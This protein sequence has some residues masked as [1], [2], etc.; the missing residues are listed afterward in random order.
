MQKRLFA[1]TIV[2]ASL[3]LSA[4][5]YGQ[6]ATPQSGAIDQNEQPPA[7]D[8]WGRAIV[9]SAKNERA[10]PAPRHDISGTWEPANGFLDGL[11]G[12][13]ANAMP[14][15]GKPEHELPYTPLG[16]EALKRNKP[17][18]GLRSVLPGET[19]D[20]VNFCDPQ[21]FPRENLF[22]LRTTQ[23]LQTP[24]KILILYEFDRIWRV[25]WTDG[26]KLPENPEPRWFGYSVGHWVDDNTLVV[27]TSGIDERSWL[28][29]VGRPH[30]RDLRVEERFRRVDHDHLAWT[31]TIDDPKMYTRPWLALDKF[32]MKLMPPDFDVRE[33][34]CSPSESSEYDKLI[35]NRVSERNGR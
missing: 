26:R 23:I 13:G 32:P 24:L 5:A 31:V 34:I 12:R 18:I 11:G 3:I 4:V 16:L 9:A 14:E 29:L 8:G 22:Q 27:E 21:G 10:V 28:D 2:F 30:S 19:N 25:I 20:P 6:A 7:H 17:T 33:M 1:S 35:G 15:D